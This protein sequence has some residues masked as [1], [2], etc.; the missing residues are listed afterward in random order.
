LQMRRIEIGQCAKVMR[1]HHPKKD[2][3]NE[4]K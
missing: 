2:D 3:P 1:A 4:W